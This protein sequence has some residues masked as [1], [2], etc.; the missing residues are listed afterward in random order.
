MKVYWKCSLFALACAA[1]VNS[2]QGQDPNAHIF[3]VQ[4]VPGRNISSTTNPAY[5]IDIS[6]GS[7]CI[8]QQVNFGDIRGPYTFTP[9]HYSVKFSVASANSPCGGPAVFT[10]SIAPTAGS[11]AMGII[12]LDASNRVTAGVFPLDLSTVGAGI[13]RVLVMNLS[14]T[15]NVTVALTAGDST[16]GTPV[17]GF[18]V[19]ARQN[20]ARDVPSGQY[21][22]TIYPEGST[23]AATGPVEADIVSR[24]LHIYILAGSTTNDSVQLVGP[25]VIKDVL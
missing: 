23:T 2:V 11:T 17:S 13:G 21:S 18:P 14:A 20:V 16:G 22:L 19:R 5:P 1:L 9:G 12:F 25:T 6:I 3:V 4:A 8:V 15:S 24:N 10:G 7:I